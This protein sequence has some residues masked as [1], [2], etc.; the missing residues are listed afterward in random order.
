MLLHTRLCIDNA[1]LLCAA[2]YCRN[3]QT[4]RITHLEGIGGDKRSELIPQECKVLQNPEHD[5]ARDIFRLDFSAPMFCSTALLCSFLFSSVQLWSDICGVDMRIFKRARPT[6]GKSN[7][8]IAELMP[9]NTHFTNGPT[10]S[11]SHIFWFKKIKCWWR[12]LAG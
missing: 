2:Q 5:R 12:P 11:R 6:S 1:A 8:K 7:I 10:L 3:Q 9:S 4:E